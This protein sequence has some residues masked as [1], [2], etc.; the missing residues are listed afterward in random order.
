MSPCKT[1]PSITA[2]HVQP[3]DFENM[4]V[5]YA[6]QLFSDVVLN[7]LRYYRSDVEAKCG[8]IEPVHTF[9]R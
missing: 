3:N 8:N 6:S 1:M 5:T 9:F 4:R 2:R 7:G